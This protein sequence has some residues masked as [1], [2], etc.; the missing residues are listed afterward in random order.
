MN[1]TANINESCQPTWQILSSYKIIE[2][3]SPPGGWTI[4]CVPLDFG[5]DFEYKRSRIYR[6]SIIAIPSVKL[7]ECVRRRAFRMATVTRD[8]VKTLLD[9]TQEEHSLESHKWKQLSIETIWVGCNAFF[10]TSLSDDKTGLSQEHMK[11]VSGIAK[12][13]ADFLTHFCKSRKIFTAQRSE[14]VRKPVYDLLEWV[15]EKVFPQDDEARLHLASLSHPF[16]EMLFSE[17]LTPECITKILL[18]IEFPYTKTEE[19]LEE[20]K[21]EL[22]VIKEKYNRECTVL[23]D[24]ILDCVDVL[25]GEGREREVKVQEGFDKVLSFAKQVGTKIVTSVGLKPFNTSIGAF[26]YASINAALRSE[27]SKVLEIIEASV[28]RKVKEESNPVTLKK[29][30]AEAIPRDLVRVVN[31][32]IEDELKGKDLTKKI[33]EEINP[34]KIIQM[35]TPILVEL[36]WD[37]SR[38]ISQLLCKYIPS[39]ILPILPPIK[40]Q[41]KKKESVS[42]GVASPKIIHLA[43]KFA[44][45]YLLPQQRAM[46]NKINTHA[47]FLCFFK[48]G[49]KKTLEDLDNDSSPYVAHE[50]TVLLGYITSATNKFLTKAIEKKF[51][52]DEN[53]EEMNEPLVLMLRKVAQMKYLADAEAQENAVKVGVN[54]L[55]KT[56]DTLLSPVL[57]SNLIL[58]INL[59][60]PLSSKTSPEEGNFTQYASVGLEVV[61]F[62]RTLMMLGNKTGE[63]GWFD[64]LIAGGARL[65]RGVIGA[66]LAEAIHK[67]A[68][69]N[70][71]AMIEMVEGFLWKSDGQQSQPILYEGWILEET[72]LQKRLYE[73]FEQQLLPF[74]S[75]T[76]SAKGYGETINKIIESS[77]RP[78][79]SLIAERFVKL[80]WHKDNKA[81]KI[82]IFHY[83]LPIFI[84]DIS[85][86]MLIPKK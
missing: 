45:D 52:F 13:S 37:E 30:L 83:L 39:A 59:Q 41:D 3:Y 51:I 56:V 33:V 42:R 84:E 48:T 80:L 38:P 16:I 34:G 67:A 6:N 46:V 70:S 49:L 5:E 69:A 78:S 64:K 72:Q 11:L 75:K 68:R 57:L 36:I 62:L 60:V 74:I 53:P 15:L 12:Q 32:V 63:L 7:S 27:Q 21:N 86:K 8:L 9:G 29:S 2:D 25:L 26:V 82:Y 23:G 17:Y 85:S 73:W 81:I 47:L 71:D 55:N 44:Q 61:R 10:Q 4:N 76:I 40:L 28:M 31:F 54:L 79:L 20:D 77:L 18:S 19:V 24:A 43:L 50:N 58:K 14:V 1:I 66:K 65:Y 22:K 35:I